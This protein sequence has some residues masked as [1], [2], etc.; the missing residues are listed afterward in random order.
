M[1]PVENVI[2][3]AASTATHWETSNMDFKKKIDAYRSGDM[4]RRAFTAALSAAGVSL[5]MTPLLPKRGRRCSGR[6]GHFLHL[7]RL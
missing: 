6:S 5:A 7:G 2:L 4:S 3:K 1:A